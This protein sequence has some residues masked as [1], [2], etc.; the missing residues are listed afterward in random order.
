MKYLKHYV[1]VIGVVLLIEFVKYKTKRK[2]YNKLEEH[3]K[4]L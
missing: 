3:Y 2:V 4:K 1:A